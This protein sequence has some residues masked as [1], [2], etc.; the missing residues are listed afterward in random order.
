MK[1]TFKRFNRDSIPIWE[2]F[3]PQGFFSRDNKAHRSGVSKLF[4]W[5]AKMGN[6]K[7]PAGQHRGDPRSLMGGEGWVVCDRWRG[8]QQLNLIGLAQKIKHHSC[9]PQ[10]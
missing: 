10:S 5:G 3:D 6:V 8:A 4:L 2:P 9:Y 7:R 1:C